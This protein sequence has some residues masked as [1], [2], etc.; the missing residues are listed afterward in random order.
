MTEETVTKTVKTPVDDLRYDGAAAVGLD[1]EETEV[2]DAT[3]AQ[4][5]QLQLT[6]EGPEDDR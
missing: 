5:G 4:D 3:L 2:L 6:L 1:P